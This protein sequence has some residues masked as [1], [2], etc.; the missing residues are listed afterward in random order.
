MNI[1]QRG[2]LPFL[3]GVILLTSGCSFFGW[4]QKKASTDEAKPVYGVVDMKTALPLNPLYNKYD[5]AR[6]EYDNLRAQYVA[7]QKNLSDRA[8]NQT[9][10]LKK[11]D[12]DTAIYT[13]LDT[14]YKAR[15]T[16]KEQE[17]NAELT[18]A[19]Q[20]YM[21]E[22]GPTTGTLAEDANLKIV[23]LQL[24]LRALRL[25]AEEKNKKEEELAKL[26]NQ[27]DPTLRYDNSALEERVMKAMAPLQEKAKKE[28]DAYAEEVTAQLKNKRENLVGQQ[29]EAIIA[30]N[31]LPSPVEWNTEWERKLA[32]KDAEVKARE[33]DVLADM[34][35][36]VAVIAQEKG[37]ELVVSE[38]ESNIKGTDITDA[39]IASYE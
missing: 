38:Y 15:M 30:Q 16:V 26:L 17:L 37:L 31:A 14:E 25:S 9:E 35:K 7:E 28:L 24:Q 12:S 39:L 2:A 21:K 10:E 27:R 6:Q 32:D 20:G 4:G 23:N 33:Q 29:Q 36:R 8:T 13:S 22:Y 11:I 18:K 34:R 3:L 5:K 1:L 19:Y